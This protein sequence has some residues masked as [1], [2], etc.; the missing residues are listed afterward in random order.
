MTQPA[1]FQSNCKNYTICNVCGSSSHGQT[2][3]NAL[4]GGNA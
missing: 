2:I 4:T 1:K 3:W